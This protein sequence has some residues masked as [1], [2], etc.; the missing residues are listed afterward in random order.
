MVFYCDGHLSENCYAVYLFNPTQVVELVR[1]SGASVT[2]HILDEASYKQAK[3][4]GVNVAGQQSIPAANGDDKHVLK[5]KL[6]FIKKT[7]STF[8]FSIRSA[9]GE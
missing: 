4:Q 1:D 5:P 3:A 2:F 9:K 7:G 8:G 6:C